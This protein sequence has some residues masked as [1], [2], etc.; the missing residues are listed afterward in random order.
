MNVKL[1]QQLETLELYYNNNYTPR[2]SGLNFF[3]ISFGINLYLI[4]EYTSVI[5]SLNR[6]IALFAPTY[7]DKFCGMKITT[8]ILFCLYIYR[9]IATASD[10]ISYIPLECYL[11]FSKDHLSYT[12]I[13]NQPCS[14]GE[15]NDSGISN[16]LYLVIFFF[17]LVVIMNTATFL[18][19]AVLLFN[20]KNM[21]THSKTRMKQNAVLFL[22]TLFQDAL[23]LIDM[24]FTFKLSS[25]NDTK[26]WSFINAILVWELIHT[27]DGIIMILF[28]ERISVIKKRLFS[29]N[30]VASLM[31]P[32]RSDI[33]RK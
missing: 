11:V 8:F 5:I 9:I 33:S 3:W 14:D 15:V 27:F 19:I 20:S 30:A 4:N 10:L 23:V 7:Y 21:D 13:Y 29:K 32:S 18:K 12:L 6:F 1:R 26:L 28:N 25:E 22:Q 16:I 2:L 31:V 17:I 24:I